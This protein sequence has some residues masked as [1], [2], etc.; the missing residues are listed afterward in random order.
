MG[1]TGVVPATTVRAWGRGSLAATISC[2]RTPVAL[3]RG[4]GGGCSS[5]T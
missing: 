4:W 5:D 2:I 1:R 3:E